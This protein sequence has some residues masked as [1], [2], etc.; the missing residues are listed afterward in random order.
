MIVLAG[1]GVLAIV[2]VIALLVSSHF[3]VFGFELEH[4]PALRCVVCSGWFV[5][6][7]ERETMCYYCIA[8]E[9]QKE[10]ES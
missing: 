5:A 10:M 6:P 3:G 8:G 4:R 7:N 2:A 9:M 1:I